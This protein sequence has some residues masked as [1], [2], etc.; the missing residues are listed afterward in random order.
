MRKSD[1]CSL[2]IREIAADEIKAAT[3][4]NISESAIILAATAVE[5]Y[6]HSGSEMIKLNV[7][8]SGRD[9]ELEIDAAH[10]ASTTDALFIQSH[11]KLKELLGLSSGLCDMTIELPGGVTRPV[12]RSVSEASDSAAVLLQCKN[13]ANEY[14]KNGSIKYIGKPLQMHKKTGKADSNVTLCLF[15]P[16]NIGMFK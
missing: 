3:G 2:D 16:C 12:M 1:F 4:E 5:A 13:H 10:V 8:A 6:R 15:R 7:K 11:L 14:T 9:A